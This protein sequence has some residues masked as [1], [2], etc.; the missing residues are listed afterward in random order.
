MRFLR[1]FPVWLALAVSGLAVAPLSFAQDP[2]AVG[3]ARRGAALAHTCLGCHGVQGYKNAYP[4]YRVPKLEGQY[5]EYLVA[6]LQ[7]YR[8][9]DRSHL[10]MHSQASSLS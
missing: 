8:S 9:G 2:P 10:T 1:R 7:G 3:D 6:A 5:P 4:N